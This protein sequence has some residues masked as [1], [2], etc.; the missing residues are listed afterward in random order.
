MKKISRWIL[1]FFYI[2]AGINH[3]R[4]PDFYYPLI[5]DYLLFHEAINFISGTMEIVLAIG[6]IFSKTRLWSAYFT[7]AML[8]A[9]IPSHIHFIVIGGCVPELCIPLWVGWVRLLIVHPL[10]MIWT[11]KNRF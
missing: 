10:L 6:F 11:W 8:I 5:P 9:F 2:S 4:N 7:L 3:F 1:I